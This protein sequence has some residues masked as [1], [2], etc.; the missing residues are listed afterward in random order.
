MVGFLTVIEDA[1]SHKQISLVT[2]D[3]TSQTYFSSV[4]EDVA[5]QTE[6]KTICAPMTVVHSFRE[7]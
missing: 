5:S 1:S 4:T 6:W 7:T 2:K 3:V